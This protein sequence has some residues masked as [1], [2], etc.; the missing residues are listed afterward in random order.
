MNAQLAG[1][2]DL[3]GDRKSMTLVPGMTRLSEGSVLNVKNKSYN[4]TAELVVPDGGADGVV[5]VQGGLFGGWVVYF[6]E[7]RLKYCYNMVGV[8]RYYA[9]S[10]DTVE[11]GE[12]QIRMEFSYDGGGLAKGGDV[13]LFVDGQAVGKGRVERT[14]PFIFSAD[15]GM[16]VGTDTGLL[17]TEDEPRGPFSGK[18]HWVQLDLGIEDF[19]H[20]LTPEERYQAAM[21]RQ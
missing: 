8:H 7:G 10:R 11:R 14:M 5:L 4:V 1:R 21:M 19:D 13:T 15:D 9:E 17:V 6:K 3:M 16:D 2:P 18:I 12:H 20:L